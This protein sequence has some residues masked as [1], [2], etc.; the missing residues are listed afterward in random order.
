MPRL[1]NVLVALAASSAAVVAVSAHGLAV[2][3]TATL[4]H[5]SKVKRQDSCYSGYAETPLFQ[6][7]YSYVRDI[8]HPV[9]SVDQSLLCL[10]T[11]RQPDG[12]PYQVEG[13]TGACR[14][15]QVGYN[16]RK[17]LFNFKSRYKG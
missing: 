3:G 4:K 16:V 17:P 2:G 6:K 13:N 5:A 9:F 14:G 11:L 7:K 12:V 1:N 15:N 10:R 8:T